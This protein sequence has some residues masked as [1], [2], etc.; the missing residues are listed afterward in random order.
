MD[1][2]LKRKTE[3]KALQADLKAIIEMQKKAILELIEQQIA[4]REQYTILENESEQLDDLLAE[5]QL[6]YLKL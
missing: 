6:K 3:N 1:E 5:E 4:L 2:L